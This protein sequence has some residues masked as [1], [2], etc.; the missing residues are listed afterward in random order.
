MEANG[1]NEPRRADIFPSW[2]DANPTA[3]MF[4]N[5]ASPRPEFVAAMLEAGIR[6]LTPQALTGED[7]LPAAPVD[8][9]LIDFAAA[10]EHA[11][12]H[13]VATTVPELDAQGIAIIAA[14]TPAQIDLVALD[15]LPLGAELLCDP[16]PRELRTA[17]ERASQRPSRSLHDSGGLA[18]TDRLRSIHQDVTRLAAT[19]REL[20]DPDAPRIVALPGVGA[21]AVRALIRRRRLRER[22][23]EAELF[24][25]PAWDI[26]LDLYASHLEGRRVCVSS[27][28]YAAEVPATTAL[29]WIGSMSDKGL[30]ERHADTGDKRRHFIRLT[31]RAI[32]GMNSYFLSLTGPTQSA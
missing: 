7:I 11:I 16:A 2:C 17:L 12:A 29:R 32:S 14:L 13:F 25:D 1:M 27:L 23:F 8:L 26:L 31:D 5:D 18:S 3:L 22:F 19:L 6:T 21:A 9:A 24:A 28:C 4:A 20:V 15:L 10:D 30:L